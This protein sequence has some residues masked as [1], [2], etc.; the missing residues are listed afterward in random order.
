MQAIIRLTV[1]VAAAIFSLTILAP[2][3]VNADASRVYTNLGSISAIDLMHGTIVVEVPINGEQMTVGGPLVENA[4]LM[5]GDR[6]VQL[7]DFNVG[8][9][10]YVKWQYTQTGH[11][12][13]ALTKR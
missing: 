7:D 10:V 4:R 3:P 6:S 2:L 9:S 12:I 5:K 8:E 1:L 13:M 11:R